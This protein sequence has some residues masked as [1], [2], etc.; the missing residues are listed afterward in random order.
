MWWAMC[1]TGMGPDEYWGGWHVEGDR[2]CIHGTKTEARERFVPFVVPI[3][4][5]DLTPSGMH[6]R[7]RKLDLKVTLYDARRSYTLWMI[8]A[9]IPRIRRMMYLG[10]EITEVHDLYEEHEIGEFLETDALR[11]RKFIGR[12]LQRQMRVG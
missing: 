3:S 6:S 11:L 10:H 2:I 9:G 8:E 12:P 7:F 1:C 5:P 4:T